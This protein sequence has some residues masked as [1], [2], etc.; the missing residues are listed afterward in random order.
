M[1][2][3]GTATSLGGASG[4][5]STQGLIFRPPNAGDRAVLFTLSQLGKP[6]IR[7][8]SGPKGYDC[9]G[10]AYRSW[11]V[12]TGQYIPRVSDNQ[13][14]GAGTPVAWAHLRAGDL[15]F[16][17]KNQHKWASVYHTAMYVGGSQIVEST[18][19]QVQ[20]NTLFQWGGG[21]LMAHGVRPRA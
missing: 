8:G 12:A 20:V 16:W 13:S 10:L 21:N 4:S 17:G 14:A 11:Y 2:Q 1:D 9:S 18:S 6:Y 3:D 7:G 15:V 19:D 5:P